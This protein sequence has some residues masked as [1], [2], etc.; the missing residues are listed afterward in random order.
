MQPRFQKNRNCPLNRNQNQLKRNL[1]RGKPPLPKHRQPVPTLAPAPVCSNCGKNHGNKPYLKGKR[2]CFNCG[3]PAHFSYECPQ[4]QQ[5]GGSSN[6]RPQAK[7]RV[8]TLSGQ[9]VA[10][11]PNMIQGTCILK[12]KTLIALFDSRASHSFI[13]L[14]YAN[15]LELPMFLRL[16]GVEF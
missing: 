3:Q 4:T 1:N 8:F 14:T 6:Q 16:L 13:S 9:E 10:Q 5:K 11:D 12:N 7:G 15:E 2:V